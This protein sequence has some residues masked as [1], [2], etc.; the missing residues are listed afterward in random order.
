MEFDG[1]SQTPTL[2]TLETSSGASGD[3]TTATLRFATQ[4]VAPYPTGSTI[5]V[6]GVSPVGYRGTY[7][8]T[9]GGLDY[10]RYANTTVG[11][12]TS[13]GS[14]SLFGLSGNR[15]RF[16]TQL[17][18]TFIAD[19]PDVTSVANGDEFIISRGAEGLKRITKANLFNAIPKTPAG[20]LMPY[21]GINTPFGWLLCDGAEVL[22]SAYPELFDA[23]GYQF[24]DIA[25]LAGLGTFRL[26]DMRGRMALGLDNMN[27]GIR[28]PSAIEPTN[29]ITTI[30]TPANRVTD[31]EA[32]SV[33][34][35]SGAES[36]TLSQ[37]QIP[38][39]KHDM[40]GNDE[41]QYYAFRNIPGAPTD[42]DAIPGEGSNITERG[43]YLLNSG[44]VLDYTAQTALN[45]MNPY[46]AVNYIIYT[47]QN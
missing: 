5:I 6:A 18:E 27:N 17:S 19:K 30:T 36:R 8:V 25:T 32:D 16:F 23:I 29:S 31:P 4:T 37:S 47:G 44:G 15:K 42:T 22:I 13:R 26:P 1:Q 11:A 24:G 33:G 45:V 3:G 12:Q 20:V 39:H 34:L 46:L 9:D 40:I 38:D 10:V 21:G 28:V 7:T 43:Q 41:N 35:G 2:L 14:I